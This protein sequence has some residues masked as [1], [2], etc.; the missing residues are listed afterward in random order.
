MIFLKINSNIRISDCCDGSDEYTNKIKCEN[1]CLD[2]AAKMRE[3]E[4]KL[5]LLREQ[6]FNKRKELIQ[7]GDDFK[8]TV[9]VTK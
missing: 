2:L 6:G 3:E 8:K 9:Q 5:R 7:L 1:K 4:E